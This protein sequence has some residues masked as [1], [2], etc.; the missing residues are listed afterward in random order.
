MTMAKILYI[1]ANPKLPENSNTFQL[2]NAFL[3]EYKQLNPDDIVD[4]ID[5]YENKDIRFLDHEMLED[6][7]QGKDN[8][9]MKYAKHFMEYDKYVFAA[10]MW[11]LHF[12]AILKAYIDFIAYAGITFKYTEN[13]PI[14]L[15]SDKPR[16][17]LYVVTRGGEYTQGQGANF[18]FGEKYLRGILQFLG[19]KE[20]E[21]LSME[22][23]NVLMGDALQE[24][25][26]KCYL[27]AREVAK[28][29]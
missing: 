15:L 22:N 23:T 10:P 8:I 25:R 11:N 19:V 9:M 2:A 24:M 21:T 12:P 20:V 16:K 4:V 17:A 14:G 3:N 29:F 13:G 18:E 5:L 6:M 1:K 7:M 28:K 27:H 26:N